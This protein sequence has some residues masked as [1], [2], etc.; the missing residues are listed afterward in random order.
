MSRS[1]FSVLAQRFG[2]SP[3]ALERRE[4][5]KMSAATAAGLMISQGALGRLNLQPAGGKRVVVIGGGFA[6]LACAY[7]LKAAGYDVK[8]IEARN[9]IGGRVLSAN[10]A[11]EREFANGRNVEFGGELI[12]SNHPAWVGYAKT[13]GLE[14]MDVTDDESAMMPIVIDRKRLTEAEASQV[15]EDAQKALNQMNALAAKVDEDYPWRSPNAEKMDAMSVQ[16]WIDGCG[17]SDLAKR[18]MKATL[19]GDNGQDTIKQSLLGQ[20][21]A[22]KGGGLEKY[23]T[24][25]E[26]YR[27]KGGNDQLATMLARAIGTEKI[28]TGVYVRTVWRT[29][30]RIIVDV[31]DD[32]QF[33]CDD[34]V[35]ATPP[36][37][38]GK[39]NFSPA[40][41]TEMMPQM[42]VAAKHFSVVKERFWEKATPKLSQYGVDEEF[43]SSTWDA[44]D[45]QG[46]ANGQTAGAV[47]AAFH[48][49]PACR[50]V[51]S[52][53]RQRRDATMSKSLE[54]LFPGYRAQVEKTTYMNWPNE[55][56]AMAGYSFPAPGQVT[57]VGPLMEQ[58]HMDGHF[59]LAGE[60]TCYKFVGYMEG[61]LQSGM[62]AAR[63]IAT[64]DMAKGK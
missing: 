35:L 61:A 55:P 26:V 51:S 32:R 36:T 16:Q 6:G 24:E 43:I 47:L 13:F 31:S 10:A 52:M 42:G 28:V 46:E 58:T 2:H 3:S 63:A 23:W 45:N 17:A 34:V 60:H 1:V 50:A 38:W 30:G 20:L 14:L 33:E 41:P 18:L 5:L 62:R 57:K 56:F 15:W 12:G 21:A 7:E 64:R 9:R 11:N 49:G 29:E 53:D 39:V 19:A 40:L 44:T 48:G 8:V 37:T 25:S 59:F 4:F 22:V 54:G 27:C